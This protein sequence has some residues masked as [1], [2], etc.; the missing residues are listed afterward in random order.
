MV[1][2]TMLGTQ[3]MTR[4]TWHRSCIWQS[5]SLESRAEPVRGDVSTKILSKSSGKR[6][7]DM[8]C[9]LVVGEVEWVCCFRL[10]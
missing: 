5:R 2:S 8:L 10:G 9:L 7:E 6:T 1:V 3:E 4:R